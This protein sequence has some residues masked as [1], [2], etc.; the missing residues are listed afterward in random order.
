MFRKILRMT[1]PFTCQISTSLTRIILTSP[2]TCR[3]RSRHSTRPPCIRRCNY[4]LATPGLSSLR[5]SARTRLTA[6]MLCSKKTA[7][8]RTTSTSSSRKVSA[9]LNLSHLRSSMMIISSA[10]SQD[11]MNLETGLSRCRTLSTR[12]TLTSSNNLS[13]SRARLP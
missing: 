5:S 10:R 3:T 9:P 12:R 6:S 4:S 8:P 13:L 11:A 2:S 1:L 7:P